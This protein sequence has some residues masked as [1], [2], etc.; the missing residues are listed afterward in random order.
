MTGGAL[1]PAAGQSIPSY[2]AGE[3]RV[4]LLILAALSALSER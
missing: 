1:G 3:V 4:A 2:T